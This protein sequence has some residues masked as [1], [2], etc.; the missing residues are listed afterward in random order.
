MHETL[1]DSRLQVERGGVPSV[2]GWQVPIFCANCGAPGG[3]V[4]S[5]NMTFTFYLC[6]KCYEKNGVPPG[7]WVTPD[8][9]FWDRLNAE[10]MARYGRILTQEELRKLEENGWGPLAALVRD[11]PY[12][13]G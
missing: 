2:D 4:P 13:K 12:G 1:P 9:V 10:M 6:E 5:F 3:Y 11:S 8:T 7:V